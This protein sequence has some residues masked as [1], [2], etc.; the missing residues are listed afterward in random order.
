MKT[1]LAL[2]EISELASLMLS[3]QR[4]KAK[5]MG[6]VSV[7]ACSGE[8]VSGDRIRIAPTKRGVD[9]VSRRCSVVVTVKQKRS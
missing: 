7:S 5:V 4:V 3:V 9:R 6:E 8:Q 1:S 2:D